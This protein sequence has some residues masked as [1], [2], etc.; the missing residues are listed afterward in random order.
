MHNVEIGQKV[1]VNMPLQA[2]YLTKSAERRK[3]NYKAAEIV[4]AVE[5]GYKINIDEGKFVWPAS[6]LAKPVARAER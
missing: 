5:D 2:S 6:A 3:Y 4:E 1:I